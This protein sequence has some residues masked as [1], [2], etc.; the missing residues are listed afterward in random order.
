MTD[1]IKDQEAAAPAATTTKPK[2]A[3]NKTSKRGNVI[4]NPPEKI[5]RGY[6]EAFKAALQNHTVIVEQKTSIVLQAKASRADLPEDT[7]KQVYIRGFK[8]LPLN[9]ELTREQ[10]AMNRVNSFIAGG[11]AL[12]EDYDLIPVYDEGFKAKI[13]GVALAALA[14]HGAAHGRVTGNEDP[15]VNRLTGKPHTTQ[16]ATDNDSK[17]DSKPSTKPGG[18]FDKEYLKKV[19]NGEHPRPLISKEKAAQHLK[20]MGEQ[21]ILERVGIKGTGGA[22]RPHIKR[23]KNVYNGRMQFHVVDK[24]GQ[25]KHTTGDELQAK[26]HL[27]QKYHTY[28]EAIIVHRTGAEGKAFRDADNAKRIADAK[29]REE[30]RKEQ[31]KAHK[32]EPSK[33][34]PNSKAHADSVMAF[35]DKSRKMGY[36]TEEVEPI[37]EKRTEVKDA[38]GKVISWRDESEWKKASKKNP[39]GRIYNLSD[40]AKK[41]TEKLTKEEVVVEAQSAAVRFQKA[42]Q[43]ARQQRELEDARKEANAKRALQPQEKK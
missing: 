10:Y 6:N 18:G 29:E 43:K 35:N 41:Q 9:S 16:V 23:V 42:L 2:I 32:P 7:I 25:V 8:S 19:A 21:V 12:V 20:D 27:A 15:N 34:D 36:S 38:S 26:K 11:A 4:I 22:L 37:D 3:L 30:K 39:I 28:N 13:A 1:K 33:Y 17:S 40:K 31:A 5:E 14:A 24:K